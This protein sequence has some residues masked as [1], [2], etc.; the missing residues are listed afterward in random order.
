MKSMSTGYS[1]RLAFIYY[2]YF[3]ICFFHFISILHFF[4]FPSRGF[5]VLSVSRHMHPRGHTPDCGNVPGAP[6]L[7]YLFLSFPNWLRQV[8]PSICQI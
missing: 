3:Y 7:L 1:A 5:L 4:K 8:I 6:K 2:F